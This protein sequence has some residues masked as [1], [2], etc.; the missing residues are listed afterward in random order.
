MDEEEGTYDGTF[1]C[2][3]CGGE[4][5]EADNVYEPTGDWHCHHCGYNSL[6]H[7]YD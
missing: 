3:E 2:R 6:D 1:N 7:G 5:T 4:L